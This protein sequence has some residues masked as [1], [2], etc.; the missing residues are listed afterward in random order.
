MTSI[1]EGTQVLSKTSRLKTLHEKLRQTADELAWLVKSDTRCCGISQA[2][3]PVLINIGNNAAATLSALSEAFP[4]DTSTLSRTVENLVTAGL[5][6][7][8]SGKDDRRSVSLSLSSA[9]KKLV[10]MIEENSFAFLE[11]VFSRIPKT[12]RD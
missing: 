5:V 8:Q 4:A 7:R 2:Q 3:V 10:A 11:S 1:K 12:R 9:G 6:I